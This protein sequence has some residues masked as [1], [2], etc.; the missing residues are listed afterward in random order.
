MERSFPDREFKI[1][2]YLVSHRQMVIR[3][4]G[5]EEDSPNLDLHFRGVEFV[6]V[7][8][9]FS[10]LSVVAPTDAEVADAEALVAPRGCNRAMVWVLESGG[11][12]HLVVAESLDVGETDFPMMSTA[13]I[14]PAS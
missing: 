1:W 8:A 9:V 2:D 13:L 5:P 11:H 12:R 10:G 14:H 4:L 6:R 3:S 7:P